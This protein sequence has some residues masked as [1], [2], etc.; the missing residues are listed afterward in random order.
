M[1]SHCV[2]ERTRWTI[3]YAIAELQPRSG[4]ESAK[5]FKLK[6]YTQHRSKKSFYSIWDLSDDNDVDE[7]QT[8]HQCCHINFQP[9]KKRSKWPKL[10]GQSW[11]LQLYRFSVSHRSKC[12]KKSFNKIELFFHST[13][14][15]SKYHHLLLIVLV[16]CLYNIDN[17]ADSPLSLSVTAS[18]IVNGLSPYTKLPTQAVENGGFMTIHELNEMKVLT[19]YYVCINSYNRQLNKNKHKR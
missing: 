15:L 14:K 12:R 3:G 5:R 17:S 1:I 18:G 19:C 11:K 10:D 6:N 13:G 9:T 2:A 4:H 16:I 7:Y 8:C